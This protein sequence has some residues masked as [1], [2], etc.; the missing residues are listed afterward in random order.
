MVFFSFTEKKVNNKQNNGKL[1]QK[2]NRRIQSRW[3]VVYVQCLY[4]T[5]NGKYSIRIC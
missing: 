5:E 1:F 3:S 2:K 4:Y